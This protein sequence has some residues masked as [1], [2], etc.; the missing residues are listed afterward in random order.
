MSEFVELAGG[1]SCRRSGGHWPER[2]RGGVL[3]IR[4]G[5]WNNIQKER[6]LQTKAAASREPKS[7]LL[8]WLRAPQ[9]RCAETAAAAALTVKP[10]RRHFDVIA[11]E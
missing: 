7:Q 6:R 1:S 3:R 4:D 8:H 10:L 9:L 2:R 5:S 11:A